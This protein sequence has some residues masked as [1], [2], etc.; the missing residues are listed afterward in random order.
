[1]LFN[2]RPVVVL[3]LINYRSSFSRCMNE[4]FV[5]AIN[6]GSGKRIIRCFFMWLNFFPKN[7]N[8][9]LKTLTFLVVAHISKQLD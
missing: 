6:R 4:P 7:I 2:V 9:R 5:R 3:T 8:R 1:M